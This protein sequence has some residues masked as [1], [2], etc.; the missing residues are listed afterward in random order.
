MKPSIEVVLSLFGAGEDTQQYIEKFHNAG[1]E[2]VILT[3]G[4]DVVL[5]ATGDELIKLDSVATEVVDTTGAG[6]AF[7]S[8]LYSSLVAGDKLET[9]VNVANA[10][11]ALALQQVGALA[12]LPNKDEVIEQ[13]SI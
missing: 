5:V 11:A 6:D 3:L 13:F 9:A 7:W 2:L 10:T 12:D 4:A 8:G 1:V